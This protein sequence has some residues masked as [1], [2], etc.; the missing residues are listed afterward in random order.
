MGRTALVVLARGPSTATPPLSLTIP[1][2]TA[3][4][5]ASL[6]PTGPPRVFTRG[7]LPAPASRLLSVVTAT[8]TTAR[9]PSTTSRSTDTA[10]TS[11]RA[12]TATTSPSST[13][14]TTK[15]L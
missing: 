10:A 12:V 4:A 9:T 5:P 11:T 2:D 6:T 7:R 14:S 1:L 3:T 8:V 13:D 15:A